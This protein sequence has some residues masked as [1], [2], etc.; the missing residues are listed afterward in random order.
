MKNRIK[1]APVLLGLLLFAS[2]S[3]M[4]PSGIVSNTVSEEETR[5]SRTECWGGKGERDL[6]Y[7]EFS[8]C[9]TLWLVHSAHY[10]SECNISI[11]LMMDDSL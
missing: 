9:E 7:T 3:N 4:A 10:G 5:K 8:L 2:G 6:T 1:A 11:S